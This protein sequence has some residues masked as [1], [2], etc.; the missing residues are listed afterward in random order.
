MPTFAVIF[1]QDDPEFASR[2]KDCNPIRVGSAVY[3]VHS[4]TALSSDIAIKAGIKSATGGGGGEHLGVVL[5]LDGTRSGFH[6]S[7]VWEWIRRW[8]D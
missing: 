6:L 1:H 5:G 4:D 2:M 3:L 8:M 7:N